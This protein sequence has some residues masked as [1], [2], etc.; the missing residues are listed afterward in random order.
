VQ[1]GGLINK[2]IE[3]YPVVIEAVDDNQIIAFRL[4]TFDRYT[5]ELIEF[6]SLISNSNLREILDAIKK[7]VEILELEG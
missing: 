3:L 2:M 4:R 1:C 5:C 6:K 7:G